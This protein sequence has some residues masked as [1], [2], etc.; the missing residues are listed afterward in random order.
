MSDLNLHNSYG[1]G[2]SPF[3]PP[4]VTCCSSNLLLEIMPTSRFW[5]SGTCLNKPSE[6]LSAYFLVD[7]PT[8]IFRGIEM[9]IQFRNP[10]GSYLRFLENHMIYS[11]VIILSTRAMACEYKKNMGFGGAWSRG[12]R[13]VVEFI[14]AFSYF[15]RRRYRGPGNT[16]KVSHWCLWSQGCGEL[17]QLCRSTPVVTNS[18]ADLGL[19]CL[20]FL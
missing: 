6:Q 11:V 1:F 9:S 3:A 7:L 15:K 16:Q 10:S 5:V 2:L 12:W 19:K 18:R 14:F 8:P 4:K 20:N 13:Q 17:P